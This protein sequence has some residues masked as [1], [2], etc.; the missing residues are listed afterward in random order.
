MGKVG[1]LQQGVKFFAEICVV[2]FDTGPGLK[3]AFN[4]ARS[5]RAAAINE[6]P[7]CRYIKK[8]G[9]VVHRCI[10]FRC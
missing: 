5:N 3:G 2:N 8:Y 6:N 10:T 9:K 1:V 4:P 7:T